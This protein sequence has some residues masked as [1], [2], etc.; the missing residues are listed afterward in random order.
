MLCISRGVPSGQGP[1]KAP[2]PFPQSK[3]ASSWMPETT[4]YFHILKT[5]LGSIN[6]PR[7]EFELRGEFVSTFLLW[8]Y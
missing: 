3:K 1:L 8:A 7:I 4:S 2:P 5:V 6:T